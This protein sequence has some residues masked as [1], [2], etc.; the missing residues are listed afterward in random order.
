MGQRALEPEVDDRCN[1]D[2][3][4]RVVHSNRVNLEHVFAAPVLDHRSTRGY[5][6]VALPSELSRV[7]RDARVRRVIVEVEE[8]LWRRAV[9]PVRGG[10]DVVRISLAMLKTLGASA[11]D[12]LFVRVL[13]D[14]EPDRIDLCEE[15]VNAFDEVPL[16]AAWFELAMPGRQRSLVHQVNL[17]KHSGTRARRAA[18][19]IQLLK[20]EAT[21]E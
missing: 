12:V 11:G 13:P 14:P 10:P 17:A 5:L 3:A 4:R 21:G 9:I 7:Y 19:L 16:A 8:H 15:L 2:A 20:A 1:Q 18:R 6:V